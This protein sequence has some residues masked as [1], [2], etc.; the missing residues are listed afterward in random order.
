MEKIAADLTQPLKGLQDSRPVKSPSA[1]VESY[2]WNPTDNHLLT[3]PLDRILEA[4]GHLF[5]RQ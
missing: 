5:D 1:R 3:N 4:L 2:G